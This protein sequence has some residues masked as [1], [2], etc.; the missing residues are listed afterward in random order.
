MKTLMFFNPISMLYLDLS[1]H[2][3]KYN[4]SALFYMLQMQMNKKEGI[5]EFVFVGVSRLDVQI[6]FCFYDMVDVYSFK[7]QTQRFTC[8]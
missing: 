4:Q 7:I 2:I 6:L 1:Q 5:N 8:I 3:V